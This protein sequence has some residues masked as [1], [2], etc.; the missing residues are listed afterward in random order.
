[1]LLNPLRPLQEM[2]L[3]K[4]GSTTQGT[5]T[6]SHE[7]LDSVFWQQLANSRTE[8]EF[9][10]AW[11]HL[12]CLKI[13]NVSQ[14]AIFSRSS[15]I[16]NYFSCVSTYPTTFQADTQFTQIIERVN[17]EKKGI[18]L[19]QETKKQIHSK[20]LL[21]LGYPVIKNNRVEKIA[22]LVIPESTPSE[23]KQAM[24]QLQWGMAW[25]SHYPQHKKSDSTPA[26]NPLA[27]RLQTILEII[28]ATLEGKEYR[29]AALISV[30]EL[31][32]RLQCD[33]VTLGITNK[34]QTQLAAMSHSAEFGRQMNLTRSL[35]EMMDESADQEISL[36]YPPPS[37]NHNLILRAH[38]DFVRHHGNSSILTIPFYNEAGVVNGALVFERSHNQSFEKDTIQLCEAVSTLVGTIIYEKYLQDRPLYQKWLHTCSIKL[39]HVMGPGHVFAKGSTFLLC[40]LILFFFFA[41]GTY[42]ISANMNLEGT[43]Q[44]AVI[45]PFDGYLHQALP[46]AGDLVTKD[47]VL[48]QLDTRDLVLERIQWNSQKRQRLLEYQKATAENHI[49]ASKIIREQINQAQSQLSLIDQQISRATIRAPI[50]GL[51]IEG[52]LSQKIGVPMQRGQILFEITPLDS[53]RVILEI[54]EKDID[55]LLSGQK[56]LFIVNALPEKSYPFAIERIT[57]VSTTMMGH[58]VF[59]VEGKLDNDSTDLRP[60]MQGYAKVTIDQRKLIWI[61]THDLV[62]LVRMW[63]WSI[64]P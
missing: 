32:T 8:K 23:T 9:D 31:A 38:S 40:L 7:Y 26:A 19:H 33:R 18:A 37:G 25:L 61:W 63:T 60:G 11:L 29:S 20:R 30:T 34:N 27:Q 39:K 45:A 14:A 59:R 3:K 42:R 50:E 46:R 28:A 53:Y 22:I 51:I 2:T 57:P 16:E 10:T 52:D 47:Q 35:E 58:N 13:S 17:Q 49:A 55:H 62:D 54:D 48:A 4:R 56:G 15:S 41:T 1:M 44:R 43:V 6:S 21:Q 12:Q 5:T 64:I 24:R 36:L